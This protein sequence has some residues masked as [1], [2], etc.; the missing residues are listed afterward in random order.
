M[1]ICWFT[2][3]GNLPLM[4]PPILDDEQLNRFI[5]PEFSGCHNR[6]HKAGVLPHIMV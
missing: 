2:D 3:E 1:G 6:R 5:G 4:R